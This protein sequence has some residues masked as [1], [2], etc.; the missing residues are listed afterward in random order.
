MLEMLLWISSVIVLGVML[1]ACF[2]LDYYLD[3]YRKRNRRV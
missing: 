2:W 3:P 1:M